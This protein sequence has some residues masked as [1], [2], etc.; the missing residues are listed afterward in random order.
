MNKLILAIILV[1]ILIAC[2]CLY[3]F[4]NIK[5]G[6]TS[7]S[8]AKAPT[9][10]K[11]SLPPAHSK[12]FQTLA[13]YHGGCAGCNYFSAD[14]WTKY[15]K[16]YWS[17]VKYAGINKA[18][19]NLTNAGAID[20]GTGLKHGEN[21]L[22]YWIG[23]MPAELKS[24]VKIGFT[25][26]PSAKYPWT[27]A[28]NL[29]G[30]A[31]PS[32][33]NEKCQPS[34]DYKK[35][36]DGSVFNPSSPSTGGGCKPYDAFKKADV[37][38]QQ[39]CQAAFG[40]LPSN[41]T[42]CEKN[43]CHGVPCDG[44]Q[45][46]GKSS[47][48][49]PSCS[50]DIISKQSITNPNPPA[51]GCPNNW[52]QLMN[53]ISYVNS[54]A[55][56]D[57]P[58]ISFIVVDGEGEG[59]YT[60]DRA[61]F[62]PVMSAIN[63][64]KAHYPH[65]IPSDFTVGV[66]HGPGNFCSGGKY[67][68]TKGKD[69]CEVMGIDDAYPEIYWYGELTDCA[70]GIGSSKGSLAGAMSMCSSTIY[71]KYIN[72]PNGLFNAITSGSGAGKYLGAILPKSTGE[73]TNPSNIY[74]Y[75]ETYPMFS[76]ENI[77]SKSG[78]NCSGSNPKNGT[79]QCCIA[80][81]FYG[82]ANSCGSFNGFGNWEFNKF[83]DFMNLWS[84]KFGSQSIAIYE[85]AF[86]PTKW[87]PDFATIMGSAGGGGAAA[88]GT[89]APG[90]APAPGGTPTPGPG[91]THG[92]TPAT[93]S[94]TSSGI[95]NCQTV[96]ATGKY[97]NKCDTG[98]KLD[99]K[100]KSCLSSG[101]GTSTGGKGTSGTST[102]GKGTGGK[103]T[104]GTTTGGKSTGG[105][106]TSGT[107]TGGKST[108][109]TS[110]SGT[111]T[112]GK[113]TSGTGT[114]NTCGTGSGCQYC[115]TNN[116]CTQIQGCSWDANSKLCS[117]AGSSTTGTS[118]GTSGSADGKGTLFLYPESAGFTVAD[119]GGFPDAA[120]VKNNF[121]TIA[122]VANHAGDY[123][124]QWNDPHVQAL[125]S[126]SGLPVTKWLAYYFGKD[127]NWACMCNWGV[128]G[129]TTSTN[130]PYPTCT[131]RPTDSTTQK[132]TDVK[133]CTSCTQAVLI[134]VSKN[135]QQHQISGILFDDEVGQPTC[136]VEAMEQAKDKFP[137]LQL[138]WTK[139]LGNAK[140][141]SPENL[142]KLQWD[143]CLGQAYTDTTTD[144][145]N[146]NCNFASTFWTG[147]ASKYDSSVPA[148]RGVPMVCGAG[149]CQEVDGCID[150]RMTGT[151][152][153]QLLNKRPP[154]G[155][156]KWRNFAIWY[157]SYANPSNCSGGQ[158]CKNNDPKCPN[159]CCNAWSM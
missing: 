130:P 35:Q 67:K 140:Q 108:G 13:L 143:I 76:T 88:G 69:T 47:S 87:I 73:I 93:G 138:G 9:Q 117:I 129:D 147:V 28:P 102:G 39:S 62:C 158:C 52:E 25:A 92:S 34:W 91:G 54:S 11:S 96:D 68:S 104:S 59:G 148:N 156:F 85:W 123:M 5:E 128:K 139:S 32:G 36:N 145:Y 44:S 103:G 144:L 70:G 48:Y 7:K 66:A 133:D 121:H 134:E 151:Q 78:T 106:S 6:L 149:N 65:E 8:N 74:H 153:S 146:G 27:W 50:P 105:T 58:K 86:I 122:V 84:T 72:D 154:P 60:V 101:S 63:Y 45:S 18:M 38:C 37:Y 31:P 30:Q 22:K 152:I 80:N 82:Q 159:G 2:A 136:I 23:T 1:V 150:E 127:S 81:Y 46:S 114:Q 14:Q 100:G 26:F 110:T 71:Q 115:T 41:G 95:P 135:V 89:P 119:F 112:G 113:G 94:T 40:T 51:P 118:G 33:P 3:C 132:F 107:T 79:S 157:G 49:N 57:T 109:G 43:I 124:S 4:C 77:N 90:G 125:K 21:I 16:A 137:S 20:T 83:M 17:F 61:G 131:P 19:F 141:S 42:W 99:S 55:G 98:F 111:T 120:T 155:Q 64:G 24:T 56:G 12:K 126:A 53:Y 116:A 10:G 142:G 15:C 97:C 75:K 29:K